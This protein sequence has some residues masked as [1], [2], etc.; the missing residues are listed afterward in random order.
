MRELVRSP[1]F[2]DDHMINRLL[3]PV[4][5]RFLSRSHSREPPATQRRR[6]SRTRHKGNG[7]VK[8]CGSVATTITALPALSAA[9]TN[10]VK[11]SRKYSSSE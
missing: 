11:L 9:P 8:R 4:G 10:W 6:V 1:R 2:A 3:R 7:K 5:Y